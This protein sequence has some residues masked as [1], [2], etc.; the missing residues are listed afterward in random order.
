MAYYKEEERGVSAVVWLLTGAA[1]GAVFG[2]LY[3]PKAGS[4]LRESISERIPHRMKAAVGFGAL[5]ESGR[6]A[7]REVKEGL[8]DR[9]S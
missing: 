7:F 8:R 4:E 2:V 6:E 1:I 5:K 3:A 9:L